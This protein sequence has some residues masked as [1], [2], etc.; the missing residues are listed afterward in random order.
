MIVAGGWSKR[1]LSTVE[2]LGDTT[3]SLPKLTYGISDSP[4]MFLHGNKEVVICGGYPKKTSC[5][6]LV[7]GAWN[8]FPELNKKRILGHVAVSMEDKSFI[9]GG[10][11]NRKSSEVIER[12]SGSW[13]EGP[14]IPGNG[15]D[16]SCGVAISKDEILLIGGYKTENQIIKYNMTSNTWKNE[17][18]KETFLETDRKHHKCAFFKNQLF[19]TGGYKG[20]KS[21]DILT[22]DPF[23]TS[24][25]AEL[26]VGRYKHGLGLIHHKGKLTLAAFG[27][28]DSKWKDLD[29]VEVF[30][31][32]TKTWELST[33]LR[34]SEKK[35]N[36]GFL[37]VPSHLIC[38]HLYS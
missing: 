27:G 12:G 15:I 30:N 24:K 19:I 22:L 2:L 28:I 1:I 25:G 34:L 14:L 20:L 36:F 35:Y 13:K 17:T 18:S 32:D 6:K 10:N 31:E 5:L 23:T 26:N 21:V 16:D 4:Q 33:T 9:F 7:N 29:S 8:H 38:P 37:S 11:D 3:C